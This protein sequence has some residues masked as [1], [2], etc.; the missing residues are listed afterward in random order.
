MVSF[1]CLLY[2]IATISVA[3]A[4]TAANFMNSTPE[5]LSDPQEML[6]K[7]NSTNSAAYKNTYRSHGERPDFSTIRFQNDDGSRNTIREG[8]IEKIIARGVIRF[9]LQMDFALSA[10]DSMNKGDRSNTVFSPIS[11]ALALALAMI[12]AAGRTYTE[13]ANVLGL[14]AGVDL[15]SR[16]D[17]IH[18]HFGKFIKRIEE[19]SDTPYVT[20]A[21]AIF[22][23][24]G[25]P[26]KERFANLSKNTYESEV[27]NLDFIG[28]SS[29]AR[30]IINK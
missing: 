14:A 16:G 21:G 28:H 1:T 19:Y 6:P 24:D 22:V 23:Q 4:S 26:I 8:L 25:F 30:D 11:I 17:E 20:M 29:E 15:G 3:I 7:S 9:A 18:Y 27:L 2:T 10:D 13:I 5:N 12:G